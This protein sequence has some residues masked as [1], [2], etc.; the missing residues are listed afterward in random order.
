MFAR[1]ALPIRKVPSGTSLQRRRS[2]M[3]SR[4]LQ[5]PPLMDHDAAFKHL[6]DHQ[7]KLRDL[8]SPSEDYNL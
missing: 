3:L 5:A 4:F 6:K 7:R 1:M 2:L 8:A